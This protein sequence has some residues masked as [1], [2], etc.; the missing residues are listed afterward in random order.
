MYTFE[1]SITKTTFVKVVQNY[2]T[3]VKVVQKYYTFLSIL[4]FSLFNRF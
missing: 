3:F 2:N 1:K 4:I